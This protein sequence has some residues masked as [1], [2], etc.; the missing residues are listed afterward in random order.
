MVHVKGIVRIVLRLELLKP[1]VV[2]TICHDHRIACF[3][4]TEVIHIASGREEGLHLIVIA[5]IA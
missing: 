3:V 5:D 4:I 2:G 1:P